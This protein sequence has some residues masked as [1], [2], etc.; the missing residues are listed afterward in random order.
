MGV[1]ARQNKKVHERITFKSMSLWLQSTPEVDVDLG[2]D[3]ADEVDER[4]DDL[5]LV[6][7]HRRLHPVD[8]GLGVHLDAVSNVACKWKH[9]HSYVLVY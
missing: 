4:V 1:R 2:L 7:A 5:L 8:L 6:G 9:L 3:V